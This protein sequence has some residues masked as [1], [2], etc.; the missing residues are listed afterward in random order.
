MSR[1]RPDPPGDIPAPLK[2]LLPEL[3]A[4]LREEL[5]AARTALEAAGR[6]AP[7]C[8]AQPRAMRA[9][10]GGEAG[11]GRDGTTPQER[12]HNVKG[13]AMRFGLRELACEAAHARKAVLEGR[14]LQARAILAYCEKLLGQVEKQ[15]GKRSAED[16]DNV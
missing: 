6:T 12:L 10:G 7:G 1:A 14:R 16:A 5:A 8:A 11:F 13:A 4:V 3:C 2:P 9:Q 15:Y